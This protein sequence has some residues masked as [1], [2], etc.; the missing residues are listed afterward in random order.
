MKQFII[1][2]CC[3]YL[4]ACASSPRLGVDNPEFWKLVDNAEKAIDKAAEVDGEWRDSRAILQEAINQAQQGNMKQ[5]FQMAQQAKEQGEM[6]YKQAI[7]QREVAG[8]WLF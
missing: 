3:L 2:L 1:L 5:A 4:F 6:G 8:P 7:E